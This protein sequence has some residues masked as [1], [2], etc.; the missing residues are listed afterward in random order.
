MRQQAAEI[1]VI[2]K[3]IILAKFGKEYQQVTSYYNDSDDQRYHCQV[4]NN[5][6]L[7]HQI[8]CYLT[9]QTGFLGQLHDCTLVNS[10]WL[11]HIWNTKLLYRKY[12]LDYFMRTTRDLNQENTNN[13]VARYWERLVNLKHITFWQSMM[14]AI[15]QKN[16]I[17]FFHDYP[18]LRNIKNIECHCDPKQI[19][20]LRVIFDACV[21]LWNP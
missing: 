12:I 16:I 7:M 20:I 11:Y 8:L 18:M 6:D 2:F 21:Q 13:S 5:D 10:C 9:F 19:A 1:E 15:D 4:F 17:Y 3:N 14:L